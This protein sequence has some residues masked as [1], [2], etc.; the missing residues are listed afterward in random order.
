MNRIRSEEPAN[1]V[2]QLHFAQRSA[3][4]W[5]PLRDARIAKLRGGAAIR[6]S[7]CSVTLSHSIPPCRVRSVYDLHELVQEFPGGINK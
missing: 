3:H 5:R 2:V 7:A 4:R 6:C 1:K